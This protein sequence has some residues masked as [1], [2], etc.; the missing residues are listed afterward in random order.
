VL[1]SA[2]SAL[3]VALLGVAVLDALLVLVALLFGG[4]LRCACASLE[5]LESAAATSSAGIH[6]LLCEV[7]SSVVASTFANVSGRAHHLRSFEHR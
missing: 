1:V 4:R 7:V 3:L 5:V 6:R 2:G